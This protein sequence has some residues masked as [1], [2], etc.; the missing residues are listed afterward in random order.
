MKTTT[1]RT[2]VTIKPSLYLQVDAKIF[3]LSQLFQVEDSRGIIKAINLVCLT[4]VTLE[5]LQKRFGNLS[6]KKNDK[7]RNR[8]FGFLMC[9]LYEISLYVGKWEKRE[10]QK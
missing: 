4:E 8:S 6:R 1:T 7:G 5:K 2:A 9:I 10:L 3:S